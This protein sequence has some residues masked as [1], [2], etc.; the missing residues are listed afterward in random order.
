MA[1]KKSGTKKIDVSSSKR[2][3]RK[4]TWVKGYW[5]KWT[6]PITISKHK[7]NPR[8]TKQEIARLGTRK[9][10]RERQ[11]YKPK[12]VPNNLQQRRLKQGKNLV[13]NYKKA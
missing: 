10:E 7:R 5:R 2:H 3:R 1:K 11:K 13:K 8:R 12:K 4:T 6:R 9:Q